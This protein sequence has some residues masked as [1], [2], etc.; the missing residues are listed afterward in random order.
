MST[1]AASDSPAQSGPVSAPTAPIRFG[2]IGA[3]F[4]A[5]WFVEAA[6]TVPDAEVVAVTSAH[7]ER[8]AAFAAE[9]AIPAA[10][11]SLEEMLA[12]RDADGGPLVDVVYVGS[13]NLLHPEHALAALEAGRHVLVEKPFAPTPAQAQAMVAAARRND[14]LLMEGWLPAFEPGTAVLRENLQRLG[15]IRRALL[16]K[17]QYSSRMDAYRGGALP[18]A[19]NP[20]MAGGS[21]MDLGVYPI[22]LAIHLFGAPTRVTAAGVLLDSGADA[23]GTVVLDYAGTDTAR[24][25][26]PAGFEVVCL[27]SKTSPAGTGSAIAGDHAVLTLDD[28]QWPQQ[29]ALRGPAVGTADAVQD[30]SVQRSG[31]VLAYELEAFCRLVRSGARESELH[32]LANSVAAVEVLYE[33]RRQVGVRFPGDPD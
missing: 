26:Q 18:P 29:I 19:F 7:P 4:I 31:P 10:F 24:Q 2:M 15:P 28:C 20:A 1:A 23:L 27:H 21:L 8:A 12:A 6:R 30:L 3:G 16:V 32:P 13:P 11:A 9:H 22:S 33:A 17:E 25:V 5:R 14:R